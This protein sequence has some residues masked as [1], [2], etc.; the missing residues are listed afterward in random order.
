M[1]LQTFLRCFFTVTSF[2]LADSI[3]ESV[4]GHCTTSNLLF[5]SK[6]SKSTFDSKLNKVLEAL[7]KETLNG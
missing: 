1:F 3:F 6:A 4:D 5:A 2:V 7:G